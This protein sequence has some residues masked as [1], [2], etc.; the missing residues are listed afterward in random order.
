MKQLDFMKVT[1]LSWKVTPFGKYFNSPAPQNDEHH[2]LQIQKRH[3]KASH[4]LVQ[5]VL[6]H[7]C[8]V[9]V[10]NKVNGDCKVTGS[11]IVP[12]S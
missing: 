8:N 2:W 5:E 7:T 10:N 4:L 6:H 1:Y 11:S 12:L 3:Q 9:N